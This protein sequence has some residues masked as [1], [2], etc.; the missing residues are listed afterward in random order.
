MTMESFTIGT[1]RSIYIHDLIF[2]SEIIR[3][4]LKSITD[5]QVLIWYICAKI[6]IEMNLREYYY[7]IYNEII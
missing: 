6:K 1:Y 5:F 4:S 3:G 7:I 2:F